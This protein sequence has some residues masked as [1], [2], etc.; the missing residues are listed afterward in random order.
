MTPQRMTRMTATILAALGSF[1]AASLANEGSLSQDRANLVANT[2]GIGGA[3]AGDWYAPVDFEGEMRGVLYNDHMEPEYE[4]EAMMT[5]LIAVDFHK[6]PDAPAELMEGYLYGDVY[7]AATDQSPRELV[8]RLEGSW[9]GNQNGAGHFFALMYHLRLTPEV[10]GILEGEFRGANAVGGTTIDSTSDNGW[11]GPP[12]PVHVALT[13][14]QSLSGSFAGVGFGQVDLPPVDDGGC[15]D[16]TACA[17]EHRNDAGRTGGQR[18]VD[19]T[20]APAPDAGSGRRA[21]LARMSLVPDDSGASGASSWSA[22]SAGAMMGAGPTSPGSGSSA[23][24]GMDAAGAS[25][26]PE[27]A[28]P[29]MFHGRWKLFL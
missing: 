6:V 5:Q 13:T 4:V 3:A 17:D 27:R 25:L 24:G 21:A 1:S 8:G 22:S 14:A 23:L 16:V 26:V 7:R 29:G 9:E 15:S 2:P 18:A 19:G 11:L 28:Q 20:S 10:A 12:P